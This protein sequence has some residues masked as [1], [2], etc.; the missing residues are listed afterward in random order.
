MLTILS[1]VC[2]CLRSAGIVACQPVG[3]HPRHGTL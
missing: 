1:R 2:A 3:A